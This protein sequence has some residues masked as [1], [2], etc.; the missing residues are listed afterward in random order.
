MR[1][2]WPP[3]CGGNRVCPLRFISRIVCPTGLRTALSNEPICRSALS[4]NRRHQHTLL[5]GACAIAVA[6]ALWSPPAS[7][8]E[9]SGDK[10]RG[11][12][13]EAARISKE[14]FGNIPKGPLQMFISINQQRL[15][16]YSDGAHVTDAPVATGVPGHPTPMGVFSVIEKDRYHHS[17]IYS[18]APM[19][20]MQRITW[21]GVALHEGVGLGHPASHGCIRMPREFAARLWVL[22]KLGMRVIIAR[23]ELKPTDFAD[24]HLFMH[25]ERPAPASTAQAP[26]EAVKTAQTLDTNKTTDA[27]ELQVPLTPAAVPRQS[28]PPA[29]AVARPAA[30]D[31]GTIKEASDGDNGVAA[32]VD[33]APQREAAAVTNAGTPPVAPETAAVPVTPPS[34]SAPQAQI[35][36]TPVA[37]PAEADK[38]AA[39]DVGDAAPGADQEAVPI[40]LAKPAKFV[41]SVAA[42]KAPIAIFISRRNGRIYVRQNFAPLF[43]APVAIAH[44]EQ[45]IGTHVFTAMEYRDNGS[46]FRWNVVSMPGERPKPAHHSENDRK[47]ERS[48]RERRREESEADPAAPQTPGQALARIDIPQ[49]VVEQ[50]S[51]LI[52]PGSSLIVS[53]QGLGEETGE[54]T[55]FIVVTR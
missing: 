39:L 41:E 11:K 1:H 49:D 23:P 51:E 55:D 48:A 5:G 26:T 32:G 34:T 16:L 22:S 50:I 27:M 6:L 24:P 9:K 33:A 40:P 36:P 19:P 37:P 47:S 44:P 31:L 42:S 54:Y 20:Y 13:N 30:V 38:P 35:K 46:T 29:D 15:H 53:D 12:D 28:D 21:S 17:N 18:G 52:V 14:P 8:R 45:P 7:A 4:T 43:S 10:H 2:I 3:A 25:K